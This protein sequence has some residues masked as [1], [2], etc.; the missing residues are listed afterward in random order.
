V[1]GATNAYVQRGR[2]RHRGAELSVAG[3]LTP[4]LSVVA[5]GM[6]LDPRAEGGDPATSGRR[7]VGVSR[8]TASAWAR[9]RPRALGVSAGVFHTGAQYLDAANTQRVPAATRVDVGAEYTLRVGGRAVDY[10][11]AVENVADRDYWTGGLSG[12]LV[13]SSPRTVK[14]TSRVRF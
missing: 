5:G 3:D 13:L 14:L 2:Q 6:L 12:L 7:P 9:Y 8:L 4:A 1:D 10:L 11:L